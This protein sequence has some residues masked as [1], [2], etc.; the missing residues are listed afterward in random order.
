MSKPFSIIAMSLA[1]VVAAGGVVA[2]Q[3]PRITNGRVT[4]QPAP[5]PFAQSFRTLVSSQADVAWIGYSVPVVDGERVMCC[6]N[7]GTTWVNGNVIMSDGQ[8][9]CGACRLEPG[10]EGTSMSTRP[11]AGGSGTVRLEGSERMTVLFRV[12]EKKVDRVRVF[13][14][15]CELDA[16]GKPVVWLQDVRPA[17]SVALLESLVVP[18]ATR[19]DRV[20]DGAISAIALTRDPAA[21]ASLD[22]LVVA[23]QPDPVR[24]KVT[25]W[26]GNA[27]GRHGMDTLKR[28]LHDDPSIEVRKSAVFGVSQSREAD[29]FDT[30]S[31]IATADAEPRLRGEA[32][33]W[34]AQKGD[35]RAPKVIL[36]ALEK[37]ASPEVRKKAVFALSQ[38]KDDAGVDALMRVARNNPD[39]GTR[40][41]AIFWLGQKA[42]RKASGAITERIEQ[43]PDTEVKKKAVFAL[44]QLPKDEGIPLL[45]NVA[46]TNT[47]PAV[48]KQAIFWLGQSKDP[49]ALDFFAEIL[50]K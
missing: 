10:G 11:Q 35:A 13:S 2:A 4:A 8:G 1:A 41:E 42:G 36:D 18:D 6:F 24:K 37:D 44:S 14:E 3:Q 45:I 46:K 30:L 20:T 47:N 25:F 39:P 7:S 50:A 33:F 27:R 9:C 40:A 26:L 48:R 17:D 15:E 23:T 28:I 31:G 38:L 29:A 49:R 19:R 34:L 5:S 12:A 43:D 16:G 21:D 22:R 32:L